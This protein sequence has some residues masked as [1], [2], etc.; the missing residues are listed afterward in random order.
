[1]ENENGGADSVLASIKRRVGFWNSLQIDI[2]N[3]MSL[4]DFFFPEEAQAS[5]LRR[6]ADTTAQTNSRAR[7][8]RVRQAQASSSANKRIAELES[9]VGQLTILVE[10][11]LEKLEE[12]GDLTR[13]ELSQ[14]IGEIDA[15]DGV[16]DG[17]ITKSKPAK[18]KSAL[19]P[20]RKLKIP[21]R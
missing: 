3:T 11:L 21:K 2:Q 5:H 4:F 9:E 20:K 6:I 18:K 15:R 8:D 17:R 19:P 13:I 16:I 10:A 12:K 7:F 1:M 14:K